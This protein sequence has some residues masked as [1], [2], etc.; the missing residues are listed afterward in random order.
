MRST[1]DKSADPGRRRSIKQTAAA[2]LL[3]AMAPYFPTAHGD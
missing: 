1:S 3:T 2:G